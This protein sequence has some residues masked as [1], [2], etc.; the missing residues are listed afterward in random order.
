MF[1]SVAL[2]EEILG[3]LYLHS[4][5]GRYESLSKSFQEIEKLSV[6]LIISLVSMEETEQKSPTYYE[7]I[8]ARE[9][10]CRYMS[11]PITDGGVPGNH[12]KF[13]LF[14]EDVAKRLKKKER[15]LIH[16]S[17]GIG[18]TGT[19]ACCILIALGLPEHEAE[20]AVRKATARPETDEQRSFIHWYAKEKAKR[21]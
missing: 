19:M 8:K 7:A 1:R 9:I 2:P 4:M 5:P 13:A 20:A 10:P 21:I 6:D 18:R 14:I 17:G 16:C 11:Y 3:K 15:L 12:S